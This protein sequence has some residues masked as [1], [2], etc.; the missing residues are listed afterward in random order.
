MKA[1]HSTLNIITLFEGLKTKA[2]KDSVGIPT[3]GIGTI[4]Y[5]DGSKVKMGDTCT[6]E[7]A[8]NW[9]ENEVNKKVMG[10]DKVLEGVKLNE[11]Q[12]S[13]II[14]LTYNIGLKGF[15][16]SVVCKLIKANP[17]DPNI[18]DAWLS[19]NKVT[20]NGKK[21]VNKGLMN[22]RKREYQLYC[23]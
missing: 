1:T 18:K 3:I 23:A 6:E 4:Q 15:S 19:W 13:A 20:I 12:C 7:Q 2:Y 8:F 9:L 5:P 21:E 10:L 16:D 17:L 14:S 22:R 11:N